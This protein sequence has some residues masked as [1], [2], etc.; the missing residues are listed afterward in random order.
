MKRVKTYLK[1]FIELAEIT[2]FDFIDYDKFTEEEIDRIILMVSNI[3]NDLGEMDDILS[4]NK[5][6]HFR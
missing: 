2:P 6:E 5:L 1:K 4:K 3:Q